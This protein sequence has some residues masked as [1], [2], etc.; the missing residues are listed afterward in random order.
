M[1]VLPLYA[2]HDAGSDFGGRGGGGHT[3]SLVIRGKRDAKN[4]TKTICITCWYSFVRWVR[5]SIITMH[6][7]M[8]AVILRRPLNGGYVN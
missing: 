7:M 5:E 6:F 3:K 8:Q 1:K 2:I 4:S